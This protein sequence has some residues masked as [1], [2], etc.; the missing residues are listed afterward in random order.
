M[1][2]SIAFG[3]VRLTHAI[4]LQCTRNTICSSNFDVTALNNLNQ[5]TLGDFIDGC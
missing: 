2:I 3:W 5:L 4:I 1:V